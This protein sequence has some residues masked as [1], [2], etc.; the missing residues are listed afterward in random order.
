MGRSSQAMHLHTTLKL[1][2]LP[3]HLLL[4]IL[5]QPCLIRSP[6]SL[7]SLGSLCRRLNTLCLPLYLARFGITSP[8]NTTI[9]RLDSIP[10]HSEHDNPLY[11]LRIALFVTHIDTLECT[12]RM[13]SNKTVQLRGLLAQFAEL[14]M[15]LDRL[16][17]VGEV[18]LLMNAPGE[19]ERSYSGE[20]TD[21]RAGGDL[22][23]TNSSH[24]RQI[25]LADWVKSYSALLNTTIQKS[26]HTL[27]LSHGKLSMHDYVLE[28]LPE[29][30]SRSQED[31]SRASNS[32][33]RGRRARVRDLVS[34]KPAA[35]APP[36]PSAPRF[37]EPIYHPLRLNGPS[38]VYRLAAEDV[39]TFPINYPEISH[40]RHSSM[41]GPL[42]HI[43]EDLVMSLATGIKWTSLHTFSINS[44]LLLLPPCFNW[45]L[46]LLHASINLSTLILSDINLG[47][48]FW[49]AVLPHIWT[50][51]PNLL[52]FHVR[53]CK[54]IK[55][56]SLA[57]FLLRCPR[58]E[59]LVLDRYTQ[60]PDDTLYLRGLRKGTSDGH[61]E[62]PKLPALRRLEA[63]W[64]WILFLLDYEL[65]ITGKIAPVE[66]GPS[67]GHTSGHWISKK[68]A[69]WVRD[70]NKKPTRHLRHQDTSPIRPLQLR[71]LV[72]YSLGYRSSD[73]EQIEILHVLNTITS[74]LGYSPQ[75]DP[76]SPSS[77]SIPK[78]TLFTTLGG[79]T[80]WWLDH[81]LELLRS[82]PHSVQAFAH[83]DILI[84]ELSSELTD[85]ERVLRKW[86]RL[87][88][89]VRKLI[90]VDEEGCVYFK[91]TSEELEKRREKLVRVL[92]K[93]LRPSVNDPV[94]LFVGDVAV[95]VAVEV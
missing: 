77:A 5:S 47:H 16:E 84:V 6:S 28:P 36:K 15:L 13:P 20:S 64:Q 42:P 18:K 10:L 38:W 4:Q 2:D 81:H 68:L 76:D 91:P 25:T 49:S 30:A 58:L 40:K 17:Y 48:S 90:V 60:C 37:N 31:L 63:P 35:A 75:T 23:V 80:A 67:G 55:A 22:I 43:Q 61:E 65:E 70:E 21:H 27:T 26:A 89:G 57:D 51:V 95:N 1:F 46:N 54:D 3:D 32:H 45:T 82:S 72:V 29:V 83:V 41:P 62:R 66:S 93:G 44:A 53:K 9:V 69:R 56:E 50:A 73:H 8:A 59:E 52:E 14:Q 88:E 86:V 11:A 19:W 39:G 24:L 94:E 87:F 12:F 78:L 33:D 7:L 92:R 79:D 74:H 85:D 71:D 34:R